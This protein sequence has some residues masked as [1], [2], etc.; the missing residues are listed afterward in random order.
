MA[1]IFSHARQTLSHS[2]ATASPHANALQ[3]FLTPEAMLTPGIAGT[4]SMTIANTLYVSLGSPPAWTALLLSFVFGVLV[5]AEDRKPKIRF[6]LYVLNSLVI[7]CMA[8]GVNSVSSGSK[9]RLAGLSLP[10]LV[11]PALAQTTGGT[12][13]ASE[14][15]DAEACAKASSSIAAA[16]AGGASP[17]DIQRILIPCQTLSRNITAQPPNS[18]QVRSLKPVDPAEEDPGIRNRGFFAPWKF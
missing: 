4:L 12:P 18:R 11:S 9:E 15:K 6:V 13:S 7:F 16:Q 10:Y 8:W 1:T 2:A 17:E 3:N 14:I 5:L